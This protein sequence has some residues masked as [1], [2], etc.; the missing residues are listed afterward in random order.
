V[1]LAIPGGVAAA[2]P[3]ERTLTSFFD[4]ERMT[5]RELTAS[6]GH[7]G[8][9]ESGV[10]D[11]DPAH[12]RVDRAEVDPKTFGDVGIGNCVLGE[13]D[14]PQCDPHLSGR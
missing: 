8:G 5:R 14:E 3:A 10:A 13:A 12:V 1:L 9:V 11:P 2:T 6:F 4:H 7:D